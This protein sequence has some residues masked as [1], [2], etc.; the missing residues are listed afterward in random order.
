MIT[1]FTA[2]FICLNVVESEHTVLSADV[3]VE[4]LA[5]GAI[6]LC[7][8]FVIVVIVTDVSFFFFFFFVGTNGIFLQ[9]WVD[10][11]F[12]RLRK[13]KVVSWPTF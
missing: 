3:G 10:F 9:I 12:V 2:I 13:D 6:L 5:E 8:C 11:A 7:R 4:N 1:V